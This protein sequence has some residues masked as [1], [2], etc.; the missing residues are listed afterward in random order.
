MLRNNIPV[1]V[2]VVT[3][4]E[5]SR[6]ARC[7]KALSAFDEVVVVDSSS[8]DETCG[9]AE[10]MGARVV[11]YMWDGAYPKK[12][13][14]CL[15]H[16]SLTYDWVFF[17]D[18][19]EII[20]PNV[21]GEIA[22]IFD[23]AEPVEAGFFVRSHYVWRKKLLR[24]GLLNSKLVLFDRRRVEFPVIDDLGVDGMG[25]I[26]GHYQPVFKGKNAARSIGVLNAKTLHDA[27]DD[28][29]DWVAR[30][31]RYAQWEAAMNARQAWPSDPVVW[32]ECLKRIFRAIPLRNV[33]A[34]LHCYVLKCGFLDGY[35][36]FDFARSRGRYYRMISVAAKTNID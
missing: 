8:E 21:A 23:G 7:L 16:L 30:H 14:W 29:D 1:S 35:S 34:F 27:G 19:D 31:L 3:K 12:R 10:K 9:I 28:M 4:N 26:E 25:E 15:D 11:E 24:Y 20:T 5:G 33:A 13:Q 22:A 2:I 6:L 36:G 18:A 17:V 32:R